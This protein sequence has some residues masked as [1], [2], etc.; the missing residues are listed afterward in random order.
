MTT[1]ALS[2]AAGLTVIEMNNRRPQLDS[3]GYPK[4]SSAL[5]LLYYSPKPLTEL[6][7]PVLSPEEGSFRSELSSGRESGQIDMR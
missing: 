5:L 6:I 7:I 1:P 3:L 2:T 4:L